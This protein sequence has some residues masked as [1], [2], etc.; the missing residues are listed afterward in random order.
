MT[1]EMAAWLM[2]VTYKDKSCALSYQ[3]APGEHF[4]MLSVT[5]LMKK[6]SSP[7]EWYFAQHILMKN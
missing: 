6:K 4:H 5:Q 2:H 1:H 3:P 7:F